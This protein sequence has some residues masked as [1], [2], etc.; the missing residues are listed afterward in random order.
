MS[1]VVLLCTAPPGNQ[2]P[3]STPKCVDCRD[4][5]ELISC[6]GV[7]LGGGEMSI[8]GEQEKRTTRSSFYAAFFNPLAYFP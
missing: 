1:P 5:R 7:L 8:L 3:R 6:L 2:Q 4:E